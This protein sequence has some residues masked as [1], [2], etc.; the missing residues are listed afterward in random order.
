MNLTDVQQLNSDK[1]IQKQTFLLSAELHQL[2]GIQCGEVNAPWQ[3]LCKRVGGLGEKGERSTRRVG[4][5]RIYGQMV[6]TSKKKKK[7][8][9]L[10]RT[11]E[12]QRST[13]ACLCRLKFREMD[14]SISQLIL[15]QVNLYSLQFSQSVKK[16]AIELYRLSLIMQGNH[17]FY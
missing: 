6:R 8:N 13:V 2:S 1:V 12:A 11:R 9:S 7:G 3:N 10:G 16:E 15:L 14:T 5:A 17:P 4:K